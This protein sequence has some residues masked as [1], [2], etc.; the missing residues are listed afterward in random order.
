MK[1]EEG[2]V[3]KWPFV[4]EMSYTVHNPFGCVACE[5]AVDWHGNKNNLFHSEWKTRAG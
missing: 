2:G 4:N 3:M 5:T 1:E